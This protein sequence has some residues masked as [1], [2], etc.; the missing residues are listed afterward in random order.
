MEHFS[1]F[2]GKISRSIGRL[3]LPK[4]LRMRRRDLEFRRSARGFLSAFGHRTFVRVTKFL[5]SFT[6]M[7]AV[8]CFTTPPS[9][10]MHE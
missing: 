2:N 5:T 8:R 4:F 10:E 7:A 9:I 6:F 1:G 3:Q